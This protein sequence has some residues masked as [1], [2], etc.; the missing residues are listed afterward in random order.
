MTKTGQTRS[1][2][3]Q[4]ADN[5][6][7]KAF[8]VRL[9]EWRQKKGSTLTTMSRE[10]G[11]SITIIHSWENGRR[12][13]SVDHLSLISEFT[14]ISVADFLRPLTKAQERTGI[15]NP[16]AMAFASRLRKWR[17][18]KGITLKILAAEL[19]VSDAVT[20]E[21]ENGHRFPGMRHL[22]AI[23]KYTGIPASE[24]IRAEG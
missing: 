4:Y 16:L 21:W 23:A 15:P 22:S 3:T 1:P 19:G 5:P 14:G 17:K 11:V 13:P 7:V 12:F 10:M 9:R 2:Y 18:G 6:L 24:L 8:A 20:C